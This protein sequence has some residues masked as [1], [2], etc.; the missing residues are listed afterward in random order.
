MAKAEILLKSHPQ[1]K[2][3]ATANHSLTMTAE[4]PIILHQ[5]LHLKLGA[6]K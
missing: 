3:V 1:L 5:T 6:I 4:A 2:Q